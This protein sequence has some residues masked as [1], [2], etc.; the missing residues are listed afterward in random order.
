MPSSNPDLTTN[1]QLPSPKP[2]DP[3]DVPG[4]IKA[5]ADKIDSWAAS[6]PKIWG[7]VVSATF[8]A[9]GN[10]TW[11]HGLSWAPVAVV[12]VPRVST[13]F[14]TAL[15]INVRTDSGMTSSV[16]FRALTSSG[17][18]QG[19]VGLHVIATRP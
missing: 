11:T 18:Y 3:P 10:W 9:N 15:V 17:P 13:Q 4:D 6:Q 1:L 7:G 5:L 8:D 14:P 16:I 19:D 2:S 12:A